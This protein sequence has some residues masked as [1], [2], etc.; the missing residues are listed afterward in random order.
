MTSSRRRLALL[1]AAA[2][3]VGVSGCGAGATSS[4]A[5]AAHVRA[6]GAAGREALVSP[7][8]FAPLGGDPDVALQVLGG[9]LRAGVPTIE[10]QVH[11]GIAFTLTLS[12]ARPGWNLVRVDTTPVSA[13]H[14]EQA[15]AEHEHGEAQDAVA[16]VGTE[17][18]HLQ[19][20]RALPGVDGAWA[21]IK[22]P[23]GESTIY[24]A[25]GAEHR[26][27]FPVDTGT[28]VAAPPGATGPDGPECATRA[29]GSLLAGATPEPGCPADRLDRSDA[30][31]LRGVVRTLADR[32]AQ[33]IALLS[34]SSGRGKAAAKLVRAEAA[35]RH[36]DVVSADRAPEGSALLVTS[37]WQ[38]ATTALA[39]TARAQQR[40]VR[41]EHGVWLAPWLLSPGIVDS[42][43]GAVLPLGFDIRSEEAR[44]YATA[45]GRVL[46][47]TAPT[48]AGFTGWSHEQ[49]SGQDEVALYAASRT[50]YLPASSGHAHHETSVA[51]FPGGTV[52]RVSGPLT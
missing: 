31:G 35:R 28:G 10:R 34:N 51:W 49:H 50:A 42:A 39:A 43:S 14:G 22:L 2:V 36:V 21:R 41:Y 3:T 16:R 27:P 13:G 52:T 1:L 23:A 38:P 18:N 26:L 47:G 5:P 9:E 33:A 19:T 20:A 32:G 6:A 37:G 44:A 46:P 48:A 8:T 24:V 17:L 11:D 7:A 4:D 29:V 12:P 40:R 45:L 25:H 30:D 15:H